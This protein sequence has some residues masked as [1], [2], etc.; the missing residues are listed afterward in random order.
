MC[1]CAAPVSAQRAA[2]P[3][4]AAQISQRP[5]MRK[6]HACKHASIAIGT[7]HLRLQLL[8]GG[9]LRPEAALA[10][11]S[12]HLQRGRAL[13]EPL[14]SK[15]DHQRCKM[16]LPAR[17][18][19]CCCWALPAPRPSCTTAWG[20]AGCER[21][22]I[23]CGAWLCADSQYSPGAA[24]AA[25]V[26]GAERLAADELHVGKG[27]MR[28]LD[29]LVDKLNQR[30]VQSRVCEQRCSVTRDAGL[31][32]VARALPLAAGVPGAA[33]LSLHAGPCQLVCGCGAYA[34]SE[35]GAD[36][37]YNCSTALLTRGTPGQS[38]PIPHQSNWTAEQYYIFHGCP[39]CNPPP[40]APP[41][42]RWE[43]QSSTTQPVDAPAANDMLALA[44]TACACAPPTARTMC[45]V[46][47]SLHARAIPAWAK[48]AVHL[49]NHTSHAIVAGAARRL[50]HGMRTWEGPA[51]GACLLSRCP[52]LRVKWRLMVS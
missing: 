18:G 52:P 22:P 4:N 23:L 46:F 2:R 6:A 40:S 11:G 25:S 49:R 28:E 38:N 1:L 9:H 27:S 36:T 20:S 37:A 31:M 39:T 47:F 24:A 21:G 15:G 32:V 16:Q 14:P 17:C 19:P 29:R 41:S 8:R 7:H 44:S 30:M 13:D 45:C 51:C 26:R 34:C 3:R 42:S 10:L 48:H 35:P 43:Q 50:R 12:V 33:C 5:L